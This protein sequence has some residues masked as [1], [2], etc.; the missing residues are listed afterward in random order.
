MTRNEISD[1]IYGRL[2]YA[3]CDNCRFQYGDTTSFDEDYHPCEDCHRKEQNW[4]ISKNEADRIA[5]LI[6]G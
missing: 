3:Y 1:L 2:D 6:C 5:E 4:A